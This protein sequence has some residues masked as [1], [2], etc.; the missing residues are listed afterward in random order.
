[1]KNFKILFSLL[2]VSVA[3]CAV[4]PALLS[5]HQTSQD[6]GP[7]CAMNRTTEDTD[8]F[9]SASDAHEDGERILHC[10][11]CGSCSNLHDIEIYRKTRFYY[12]L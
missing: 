10:G 6:H 12:T 5:T 3:A 1:M 2:S 7:V 9:P 11:S 4:V 8:T